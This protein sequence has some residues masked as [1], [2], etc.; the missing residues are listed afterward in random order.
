MMAPVR[1]GGRPSPALMADFDFGS[2]IDV[3]G[4]EWRAPVGRV[5]LASVGYRAHA[6]LGPARE[7]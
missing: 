2:M 6:G 7:F 5:A 4:C 1:P 3:R